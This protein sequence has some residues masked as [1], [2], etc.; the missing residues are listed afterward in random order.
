MGFAHATQTRVG[1]VWLFQ[2][3]NV[4]TQMQQR[5]PVGQEILVY[6]SN[7]EYYFLTQTRNAIRFGGLMYNYNSQ[8]EFEYVVETLDQHK[9]KYVVWDTEF[10]NRNLK[11]IFPSA[12]P[13]SSAQLVVE[14][15][16][17]SHYTTVWEE[18]GVKIMERRAAANATQ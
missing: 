16:L 6:T 8:E 10:M 12:T 5:I 9:I 2:A 1:R 13:A 11:V 3:D 15:Y 17:E 7:P 18:K 14:P 4:L